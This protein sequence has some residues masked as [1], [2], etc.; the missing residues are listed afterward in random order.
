MLKRSQK[1]S[2][3]QISFYLEMQRKNFVHHAFSRSLLTLSNK[4]SVNFLLLT[5][6]QY[7]PVHSFLGKMKFREI[8]KQCCKLRHSWLHTLPA[9]AIGKHVASTK[10]HIPEPEYNTEFLCDP[11]N[12]NIILNNIKKRKS[13]GDIDK[14][15]ELSGKPEKIKLLSEELSRIPNCTHSAILEYGDRPELLKECGK[16]PEFDF[17]PQEFSQLVNNLKLLRTGL[18]P[19]AGQKAYML[20]GDLAQ[21]EEAL[22]HY[23]VRKLLRNGF[24]LLSVPDI[25]PT[26]LIKRCGFITEGTRTLV[27][28]MDPYYGDNYSLSGTAEMALAGRMMNTML[29][30]DEL[31]V[32][33]AAVSRCY[34]AETSTSL[35]QRGIYR[36]HQFTKVEMFVC[37][38]PRQSEEV[39]HDLQNMQEELFS[40]LGLHFR[41]MDMPPTDL[42]APAY[43]KMSVSGSQ[44]WRPGCLEERCTANCPVAVIARTIS[45]DDST[46]SLRPKTATR[47]MF[48]R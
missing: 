5:R 45:Q 32:K 24:E 28:N 42:G 20:L 31:P 21:L 35:D 11:A 44:I 43:R 22:V 6:A 18:G 15:L 4:S 13:I 14:V 27:Y 39:F 40:S 8:F 26:E 38:E 3:I 47:L 41:I 25:I 19:I 9:E 30:Y 37:C 1:C 17:E 7:K 12:R 36:V 23:T 33:L 16:K 48:T 10:L 2:F 46:S 34:R 29:S